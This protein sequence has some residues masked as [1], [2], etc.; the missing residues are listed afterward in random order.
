MVNNLMSI[1][2]NP[3]PLSPAATAA[4]RFQ[5]AQ[6]LTEFALILPLLLLFL[7]GIIE[8]GRLMA[9]FSSISSAAR[10]ASRYG[11]V[12][13]D[14]GNGI[15][16]YL[17][18]AGMRARA[19]STSLLQP[20]SNSDIY[21]HYE[22][23]D[24][25]SQGFLD[26]GVCATNSLTPTLSENIAD[27][28]RVVISITATYR[29]LVPIVPLPPI[30]MTFVAAHSIFT[31]IIGPTPTPIPNPDLAISKLGSPDHIIPGGNTA[32]TYT[33]QITNT[34]PVAA[35]SIV[36]TDTL[37][38]NMA[39]SPITITT[40][41]GWSGCG[42]A[43][44]TITCTLS[45]LGAFSGGN[46]STPITINVQAPISPP[47]IIVNTAQVGYNQTDPNSA[48]N[49]ATASTFIATWVDLE[50]HKT[51]LTNPV[52]AGAEVTYALTVQNN[53][54]VNEPGPILL[55]DT[56]P[57]STTFARASGTGWSQTGGCP[58][59]N[60]LTFSYNGGLSV[61]STTPTLTVVL[62]APD[63]NHI[64]ASGLITN[65]A[66]ATSG[67]NISDPF[68]T[69]NTNI[70]A[71]TAVVA[72][73]DLAL[74]KTG[75]ATANAGV[76]F[77]YLLHVTN[78]GGPAPASNF[79]VTDTVPSGLAIQSATGT[80]WTC[81]INGQ[82]VGCTYSGVLNVSSTTSDITLNV[83]PQNATF[84][85]TN[86][87]VVGFV[88]TVE[89]DSN[90]VNDTASVTTAVT[91]CFPGIVNASTSDVT[92]HTT[93]SVS[94]DSS[95]RV[96][97]TVILYDACGPGHPVSAP[98]YN[99]QQVTL[100]SSRGGQDTVTLDPS[101]T[102][103]TGSGSNTV[104]FDVGSMITGTSTYTAVA[105][106][107]VTNA[108]VTIA[109]TAQVTYVYDCISITYP[110]N[111][112][113]GKAL[114]FTVNNTS[115][116]ARSLT[117][118]T[119]SWSGTGNGMHASNVLMTRASVYSPPGGNTSPLTISSGWTNTNSLKLAQGANTT[120]EFDFNNGVAGG[121]FTLGT[122][123]D[124]Q[125]GNHLCTTPNISVTP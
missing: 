76:A 61:G 109:Q 50:L 122:T 92:P 70:T 104:I 94:A 19:Q 42:Q 79:R 115:S 118:L 99:P 39:T 24:F 29:P 6:G 90:P 114:K 30:P 125:G 59:C 17:D 13:G 53:N 16:Y 12:G 124:D 36:V 62:I 38:S 78:N 54:W 103:P 111:P 68:P 81:N 119:L 22:K 105:K 71:T 120:L 106:D 10:Q 34:G 74:S 110:L 112:S 117:G 97:L 83:L 44:H 43:G 14:S 21:I 58:T 116:R 4:G 20:L 95:T 18:C 57:V 60:P 49:T 35:S 91:T 31:Q 82:V 87:A 11:A 85:V 100:T 93:N 73:A 102:N 84:T 64:P 55:T 23:T 48:N 52:Q 75:P 33:I 77:N 123:W 88:G 26:I 72:N 101:S 7:L 2:P 107:T 113:P 65:T 45:F 37:P 98:P 3:S 80:N 46:V 47:G 56:M 9:I 15:L 1:T 41:T 40:G 51:S 121:T 25:A 28:D 63:T 5:R 8:V 69:N 86:S 32:L 89:K 96:L 66:T 108:T 27:G 67:D